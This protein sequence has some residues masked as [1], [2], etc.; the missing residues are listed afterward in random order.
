VVIVGNISQVLLVLFVTAINV[1]I[2]ASVQSIQGMIGSRPDLFN[3]EMI[4]GKKLSP[5]VHNSITEMY[6]GIV[7]TRDAINALSAITAIHY[8]S[9]DIGAH[10]PRMENVKITKIQHTESI[11]ARM[12]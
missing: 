10:F 5:E 4:E 12:I 6:R 8:C 9:F 2:V 7:G 3:T 1:I 11:I